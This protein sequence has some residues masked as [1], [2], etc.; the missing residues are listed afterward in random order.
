[1]RTSA[2][3]CTIV[4]SFAPTLYIFSSPIFCYFRFF[5]FL[6]VIHLFCI[7]ECCFL[8]SVH[9]VCSHPVSKRDKEEV[10]I[11][12]HTKMLPTL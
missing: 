7:D 11:L 5:Y 4:V 1:M 3:L 6:L 12:F 8:V 10:P 2:D 9:E